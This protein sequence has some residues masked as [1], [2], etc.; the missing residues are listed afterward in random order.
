MTTKRPDDL[1]PVHDAA[2]MVDRSLSSVRGW[3]RT[4]DLDGYREDE[5]KKNSRLMVSEAALMAYVAT[6]QK[7]ANPGRKEND[8]DKVEA[9]RVAALE[10]ELTLANALKEAEQA[11]AEALRGTVAA[12]EM[13]SET[14][15]RLVRTERER[16]DEWKD[17]AEALEAENRELRTRAGGSWWRRM[18]TSSQPPAIEA[19]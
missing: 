14:M 6:S 18:L 5:T 19:K 16:A 15:D 13:Q 1:I 7:S 4:G 3:V 10:A 11:K 8:G 12:L 2:A 17:R 9:S